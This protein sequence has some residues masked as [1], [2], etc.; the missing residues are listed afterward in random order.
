MRKRS[1]VL[2][3]PLAMV[4]QGEHKCKFIC[5]L[6]S[7]SLLKTKLMVAVC[8]SVL[9]GC[10]PEPDPI[11]DPDP[12]VHDVADTT[13]YF[14]YGLAS[15]EINT[16]GKVAVD[17][18]DPADYRPCTVTLDGA[19]V[20]DDYE[21]RGKVRGRG[22]STWEWYPKKPYRIKL[23]EP[24]PFMGMVANRDWVLLANYRDVTHMMN[25]VGFTLAHCLGIP[26]TNH[27]RYATLKLNGK[28]MGLYM[29]TE[30]VEQGRGRVDVKAEG[31]ILLTLDI[32]DGPGD[33]PQATNNFWSE[34]IHMA[35]AV[36]WPENP[37]PEVRDFVRSEFGKLEHAILDH[38]W[39]VVNELLDVQ[40]M[41]DYLIVQEAIANVEMNN[42]P[43][44]RSVYIHRDAGGRWVMGP[45][46][47]C[48]GGFCYNWGDMYDSWGWGHTYFESYRLL[49]MGSQPYSG[50]DANGSGISPF[51]SNMFGMPQFVKAYK[52]RWKGKR[53]EMLDR[54]LAHIDDTYNIIA[55]A[56]RA[57]CTLW[58]IVNYTPAEEVEKL[59]NWLINRFDYLDHVIDAYDELSLGGDDRPDPDTHD[60]VDIISTVKLKASYPQDGHHFGIYLTPDKDICRTIEDAGSENLR[61][62]FSVS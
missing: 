11:V 61:H 19:G 16:D 59:K 49:I 45:V 57:D 25:N 8:L 40:S 28:N 46:W 42:N 21:G 1:A 55:N 12:D 4:V 29:V 37:D 38:D 13:N 47:D 43:S 20:F 7:R 35:A 18:K 6:L 52:A 44:C 32:N 23:D 48:D 36:K 22:N 33:C 34:Y 2:V 56:M 54:V 14:V 9:A 27:S 60:K 30:Q 58:K 10:N 24:F 26:Y 51:F 17:S 62:T 53:E 3:R 31:G 15:I 39:V 5:N 50:R 41:I